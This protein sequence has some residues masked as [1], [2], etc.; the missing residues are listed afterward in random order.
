MSTSMRPRTAD[1][2]EE[3]NPIDVTTRSTWGK[4]RDR[5]KPGIPRGGRT[6]AWQK[7]GTGS[8]RDPVE[9]PLLKVERPATR[10]EGRSQER[11]GARIDAILPI[12]FPAQTMPEY[13]IPPGRRRLRARRI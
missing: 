4:R 5:K 1:R 6:A 13:A 2:P 9:M 7:R 11:T 10:T 8:S 12:A 3:K